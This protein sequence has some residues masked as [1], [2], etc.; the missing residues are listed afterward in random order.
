MPGPGQRKL[1]EEQKAAGG[2]GYRLQDLTPPKA[3]P[4]KAKPKKK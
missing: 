3:K 2:G 4:K 1:L